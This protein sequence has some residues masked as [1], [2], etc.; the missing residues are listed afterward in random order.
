MQ[1]LMFVQNVGWKFVHTK[2]LKFN[3]I[4]CKTMRFCPICSKGEGSIYPV[5]QWSQAL[6]HSQHSVRSVEWR[7]G[8]V[9]NLKWGYNRE[10]EGRRLVEHWEPVFE[11]YKADKNG[12][13][14]WCVFCVRFCE[15]DTMGYNHW[16]S[17]SKHK[18]HMYLIFISDVCSSSTVSL[19]WLR[20]HV[21]WMRLHFRSRSEKIVKFYV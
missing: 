21:K 12:P 17:F 8:S 2:S 7:S 3:P 5:H 20:T 15:Q 1:N 16:P 11:F 4:G 13:A 14:I 10:C 19:S 18:T 9:Q 6:A